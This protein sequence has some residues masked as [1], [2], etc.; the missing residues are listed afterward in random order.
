MRNRGHKIGFVA[1][2]VKAL[3]NVIPREK[4]CSQF[5]KVMTVLIGVDS[6]IY[7]EC[8]LEDNKSN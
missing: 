6:N 1:L 8:I 7:F 2:W 4:L 3:D 5:F